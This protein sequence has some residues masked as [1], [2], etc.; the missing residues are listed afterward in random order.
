MLEC[1]KLPRD[2]AQHVKDAGAGRG[3][4][5][6][7]GGSGG[8]RGGRGRRG[9]GAAYQASAMYT[10]A[11][12]RPDATDATVNSTASSDRSRWLLDSGATHHFCNDLTYLHNVKSCAVDVTFANDSSMTAAKKGDVRLNCHIGKVTHVVT[13]KDVLFV[14]EL[15]A[16][17]LSVPCVDRSKHTW[18]GGNGKFDIH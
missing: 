4:G 7:G 5:R 14:P 6:R 1:F 12:A 13:L 18:T 16:N 3:R 17:L 11:A 9:R 2:Q 8:G 15:K 10:E